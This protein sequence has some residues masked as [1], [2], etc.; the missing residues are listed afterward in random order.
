[1]ERNLRKTRTGVVTSNKMNKTVAVTV[2]RKLRH[3]IYG[4][5]VKKTKSFM[6][7]DENNDCSIGDVVK[8]METRPMSKL[9]RWRL[10]EIIER[11]K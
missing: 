6:A 5:F 10:V 3:P 2:E 11:A 4:K 7:H 9:K 8:I 1:M